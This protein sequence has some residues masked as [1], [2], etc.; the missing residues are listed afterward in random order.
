MTSEALSVLYFPF[1]AVGPE[2]IGGPVDL[3]NELETQIE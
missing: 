3:V 1:R 2:R